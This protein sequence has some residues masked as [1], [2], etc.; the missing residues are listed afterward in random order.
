MSIKFKEKTNANITDNYENTP[1]CGIITA[2]GENPNPIG[3]FLGLWLIES[4]DVASAGYGF[5]N[6]FSI[7]HRA[8]GD[9]M[10]GGRQGLQVNL[11]L[12]NPSNSNNTNR[13]YVG[14]TFQGISEQGDGGVLGNEKGAFFGSNMVGWIKK[15]VQGVLHVA[16]GES[17]VIAEFGSQVKHKTGHTISSHALDK[18]HGDSTDAGI[19]I[20]SQ[21]GGVGFRDGI[22]FSDFGGAS[23]ISSGG[24]IIN[25]H[26]PGTTIQTGIDLSGVNISGNLIQS[27]LAAI[28]NNSLWLDGKQVLC[29]RQPSIKNPEN[30]L[31]SIQDSV[32]AILDVL[33]NQGAIER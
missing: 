23:P 18:V 4:D 2:T 28:S 9:D 5:V 1:I 11:T 19:G 31:T 10:T 13:N 16:G 14:A 27:S 12:T 32:I 29:Q 8:G 3:G 33:R 24:K 21:N 7:E 17:D 6:G 26:L 25:T 22:T 20:T 30:D 15:F